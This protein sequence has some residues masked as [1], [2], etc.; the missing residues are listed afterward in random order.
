MQDKHVVFLYGQIYDFLNFYFL[1]IL[2]SKVLT[3]D[4]SGRTLC[5]CIKIF[6]IF[7]NAAL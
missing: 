7:K 3:F 6:A 4:Y 1:G 2:Q 5:K